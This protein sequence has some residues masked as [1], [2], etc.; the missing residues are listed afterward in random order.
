VSS[1]TAITRRSPFPPTVEPARPGIRSL[2][3]L[4][5]PDRDAADTPNRG[6]SLRVLAVIDGELAGGITYVLEGRDGGAPSDPIGLTSEAL[7][8]GPG[9]GGVQSVI[10]A[11]GDQPSPRMRESR[12]PRTPSPRPRGERVG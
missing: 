5:E 7:D 4:L 11:I 1:R 10:R 12:N 6:A 8:E 2:E 3:D 9:E